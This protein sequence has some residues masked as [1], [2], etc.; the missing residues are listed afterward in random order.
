MNDKFINL[1][2]TFAERITPLSTDLPDDINTVL[3]GF[4]IKLCRTTI[5]FGNKPSWIEWNAYPEHYSFFYDFD[6]NEEVIRNDF[7]NSRLS[8][9]AHVIMNVGWGKPLLK[10]PVDIFFNYWY[11]LVIITGYESVIITEDGQLFMEFV[12][13]CHHLKSNFPIR[14]AQ[15]KP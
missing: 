14:T 6:H 12:R 8:T 2:K 10:I 9:Y 4:D 1:L 11:E 7:R 5:E 13:G 15:S 3:T